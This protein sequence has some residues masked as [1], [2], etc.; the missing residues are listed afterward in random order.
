ME[1][2][3]LAYFKTLWDRFYML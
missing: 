3:P 1:L 2:S